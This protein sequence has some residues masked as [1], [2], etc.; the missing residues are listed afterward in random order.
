MYIMKVEYSTINAVKIYLS[1]I[2]VNLTNKSL[3]IS[4]MTQYTASVSCRFDSVG[5]VY[6]IYYRCC[7]LYTIIYPTN[8]INN[9][10][11]TTDM[12]F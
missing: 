1:F 9:T 10:I 6:Q 11:K 8:Y 3:T 4:I 2:I 5:T 7:Y 12:S